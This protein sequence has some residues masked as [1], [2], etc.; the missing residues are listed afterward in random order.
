MQSVPGDLFN[1]LASSTY[2]LWSKK[3]YQ[4]RIFL[5]TDLIALFFIMKRLINLSFY[6]KGSKLYAMINM[7]ILLIK[8]SCTQFLTIMKLDQM[9]EA[10]SQ[11]LSI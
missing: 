6:V 5:R 3:Q 7:H 10:A 1:L 9:K 2:N 8:W 11:P 4:C